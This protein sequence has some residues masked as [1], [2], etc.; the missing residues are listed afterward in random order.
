MKRCVITS[1]SIHYTKLYEHGLS[2]AESAQLAVDFT[3]R[4]VERTRL[5]GT[6]VR[7]G[8]NFEQGLPMLM[9]RLGLK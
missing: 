7:F 3:A 2:L 9:K 8:V 4:S 5:A 6:D 1:Y